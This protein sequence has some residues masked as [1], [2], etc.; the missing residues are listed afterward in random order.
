MPRPVSVYSDQP[1]SSTLHDL[2]CHSRRY[3]S[4]MRI[5][6]VKKIYVTSS[7]KR[8]ANEIVI[9]RD[10]GGSS[11]IVSLIT[12]M[13]HQDQVVLVMPYFKHDDFRTFYQDFSIYEIRK[14]C[15]S[16]FQALEHTHAKGIMH[17]DV[18]PSNFLYNVRRRHGVLVDFGLAERED[19]QEALRLSR[20]RPPLNLD[21]EGA[22]RRFRS[23]DSK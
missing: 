23:F 10:L 15:Q 14:Y 6:A 17:R 4:E 18:K 8:I 22:S 20:T 21:L 12:A 13:R 5:V 7:P 16:L 2:N 11:K 19:D 3:S 1:S 9:L